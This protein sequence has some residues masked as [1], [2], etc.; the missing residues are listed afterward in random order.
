MR[1]TDGKHYGSGKWIKPDGS[2][3]LLGTDDIVMAPLSVTEIEGRKIP[4]TWR[5]AIARMA[6]SI[7]CAPLNAGSWMGT[8]FSYWE[9]PIRFAGTHDGVGYL[10]LTGY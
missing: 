7:E 5:I 2:A 8:G 6:L 4:T 9:G 1:Q 3:E 10:E